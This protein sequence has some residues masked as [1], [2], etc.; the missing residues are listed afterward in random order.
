[1]SLSKKVYT[2]IKLANLL[3][4]QFIFINRW[5]E[6]SE[7]RRQIPSLYEATDL[8]SSLTP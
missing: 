8:I 2:S 1:M 3:Y 7:H 5:V 4:G 6:S